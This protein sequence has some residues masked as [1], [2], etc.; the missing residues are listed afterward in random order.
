MCFFMWKRTLF[1]GKVCCLTEQW[2]TGRRGVRVGT[3]IY[4]GARLL[5]EGGDLLF[6][7]LF[8]NL[9]SNVR[10]NPIWWQHLLSGA[11]QQQFYLFIWLEERSIVET[12]VMFFSFF[13]ELTP[14]FVQILSEVHMVVFTLW[15]FWM[16]LGFV[17]FVETE[18]VRA[19][20]HWILSKAHP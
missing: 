11:C 8:D 17:E 10:G 19:G 1:K 15:H 7:V 12:A 18:S 3:D 16:V 14:W 9:R 4:E 5:T 20:E 6:R 13:T 2:D